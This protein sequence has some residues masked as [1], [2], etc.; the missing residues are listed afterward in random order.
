MPDPLLE[1][2]VPF[3]PD[4][5]RQVIDRLCTSG[6]VFDGVLACSDLLAIHAVQSLRA[7]GR[8]VPADVGVVGYDD[9]PLAAFC[10][11]TL[12]TVH[13]PVVDAGAELVAALL[14]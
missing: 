9:M 10:E 12:T 13:Q 4:A 8:S 2:A 7:Q 11:P 3:E 6:L 14:L 1:V 5:A